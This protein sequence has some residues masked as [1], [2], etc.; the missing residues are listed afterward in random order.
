MPSIASRIWSWVSVAIVWVSFRWSV[1]G[2][3]SRV[4]DWPSAVEAPAPALLVAQLRQGV[5]QVA[6]RRRQQA[7]HASLSGDAMPPASWAEQH[8]A[9]RQRRRAG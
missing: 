1:S 7:G 3:V 8:L 2:G 9:R 5:A 4:G 6:Q